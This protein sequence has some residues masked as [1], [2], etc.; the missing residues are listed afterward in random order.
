MHPVK[1]SDYPQEIWYLLENFN[2]GF[3]SRREFLDKAARYTVGGM[4]AAALLDSLSPNYAFGQQIPAN[5]SRVK[6]EYANAP[7]PQ[8]NGTI[9]GY[10]ARPANATG[11]LP[12]IVIVHGASGLNPHIEDVARRFAVENFIAYS[13]DGN[14]SVGGNPEG[15]VP[16]G[17]AQL[18]KVDPEKLIEDFIASARWVKSRSDCSGQ[19]AVLGFCYGGGVANTLAVRMPDL[20]V[21]VP[22]YGNPPEAADVAKIKAAVLVHHASLDTRLVSTWPA[23]EASL[24]QN[25]VRYEGYVYQNANHAFYNDSGARYDEAAS[26]L[27]WQRTL[28]FLNKYLRTS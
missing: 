15:T 7:S 28:A 17:E 27:S 12:G 16:S 23:Y 21:A 4:T 25:K 26:K 2:H 9:K 10:L 5:D 11:K 8:G 14:T 3:I 1:P 24:K 22:Y 13:P 19:I 18:R 6:S 20:N